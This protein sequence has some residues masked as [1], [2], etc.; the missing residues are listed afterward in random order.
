MKL[1]RI[2][3]FQHVEYED[4]GCIKDWCN[5][6]GYLISYTRFYQGDELPESADFDWLVIMG[7]AMGVYDDLKYKW[8]SAEKMAIKAAIEQNKT[9]IGICLG[10]Q[11]IAEVLGSKVYR[12]QEK[13]IGWFDVMPTEQ[14][15][16][17]PFGNEIQ[18]VTK[19]FHW[20]GDTFD[21]PKDAIQLCYSEACKNQAFLYKDN[22]LGIQFHFE[23]TRQ[24]INGMLEM[25][26]HELI[27]EKYI[28]TE[29]E[30]LTFNR[31]IELNNKIMFSIL[32]RLTNIAPP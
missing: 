2:H 18:A 6:Q 12:N 21:L 9:V 15:L 5:D 16:S 10:S 17:S 8:L 27:I 7:G 26:K 4:L 32:K 28:P 19:V 24:S 3:C 30:I 1:I 20:H 31:Y 22:V 11:L 25:G 29:K 13:E 14:G 23:V